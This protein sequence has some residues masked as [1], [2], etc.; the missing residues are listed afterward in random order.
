MVGHTPQT[1]GINCKYGCC[2]RRVDV[3]M[4]SR[5]L[6]SIPEVLEILDNEAREIRSR[7]NMFSEFQIVDY[8]WRFLHL[9]RRLLE[10]IF[11]V[12][13]HPVAILLVKGNPVALEMDIKFGNNGVKLFLDLIVG[14]R[15]LLRI[16]VACNR[17]KKLI[18]W[19]KCSLQ[20]AEGI[21]LLSNPFKLVPVTYQLISTPS[22]FQEKGLR[23]EVQELNS[24][25]LNQDAY[26]EER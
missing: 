17:R 20:E 5:V 6:N 25:L 22:L 7:T 1:E 2:I 11:C 18:M 4:S 14:R 23:D 19:L 10:L 26:I 9:I 12:E 16:G 3:A 21:S 15:L 8:R 24:R 13:V